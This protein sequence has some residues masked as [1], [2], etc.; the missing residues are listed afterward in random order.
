M[1][2]YFISGI[3]QVGI[4]VKDVYE[5]WKWYRKNLGFDIEIFD[6]KATAE[7]MLPYT[8]NKP[9]E[10]HAVLT[11][12]L[13]GG[14][15]LEIWQYTERTP[16]PPLF[17]IKL[18]DLGIFALKINATDTVNVYNEF[19]RR[20]YDFITAPANA[21]DNNSNFFIKDLYGNYV[22]IVKNDFVFKKNEKHLTG[23]VAGVM[24]GVSDIERSKKFYAEILG[25]DKVL[26]DETG[27]FEDFKDIAGGEQT[28]RRVLLTHS[29]PMK[30]AFSPVFGNSFIELIE[31]KDREPKKIF[32][33]RLWG[34]L[35]FIHLCFDMSGMEALK[36]KCEEM[37]HPFTVDSG[38]KFDMGEAAGRFSYIEDPDGTLIEFVETYKIKLIEKPAIYL[39]LQK[40]NREKSLPNIILK[41]LSLSRVKD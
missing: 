16:Q 20:N 15:G 2:N 40:R 35:G 13:K 23:G 4:G 32:D 39:N 5:A 19:S 33:G 6:E 28:Y 31:A 7:L 41:A 14:G 18:G 26:Y 30:G 11:Y 27:V 22:Q 36:T 25:Y 38:A 12:N 34:D 24:I 29:K 21:P 10:R 8:D 17:E 1:D 37:G 9:R 3:Q